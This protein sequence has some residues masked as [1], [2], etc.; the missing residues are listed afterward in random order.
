MVEVREPGADRPLDRRVVPFLE[1]VEDIR[2]VTVDRV[3]ERA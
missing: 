2:P 1:G 3:V